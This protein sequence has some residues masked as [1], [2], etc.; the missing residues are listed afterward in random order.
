M[1]RQ[2][3]YEMRIGEYFE[4]LDAYREEKTA[5]RQHI[6]ELIRG[7]T[8]RLWNLQVKKQSRIQDPVKFWQMPW[9]DVIDEA[10]EIIRLN[11]LDD[12]QRQQEVNKFFEKIK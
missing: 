4:A 6:G 1:S 10:D 2:E 11:G 3:F 5:D 8:L 7:A 9:D 12:N